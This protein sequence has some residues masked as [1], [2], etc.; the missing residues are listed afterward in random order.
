MAGIAPIVFTLNDV[1]MC[2]YCSEYDLDFTGLTDITAYIA[3]GFN[4]ST[5]KVVLTRVE[6][7]PAGTG[8]V[9]KGTPGD[10][11]IPVNETNY[12]YMNMLKGI[13]VATPV[14]TY[15]YGD[16]FN[17]ECVNYTLQPDGVFHISNGSSTPLAAN[18]AYLQIPRNLVPASANSR[19]MIEWDEE[20]TALKAIKQHNNAEGDY[21]NMNGQKVQ[22]PQK[23]IYIKN[24][25]KVIIR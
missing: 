4:P 23:G 10:Y 14:P 21:Y 3:S 1:G 5:G 13:V 6:E 17:T 15:E 11:E 8:L 20:A 9:I 12:Y 19:V 25:K 24:G 7:V 18:K 2:T 16:K 22:R